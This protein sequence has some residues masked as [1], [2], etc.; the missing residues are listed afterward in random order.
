MYVYDQEVFSGLNRGDAIQYNTDAKGDVQYV[1]KYF[2]I[3]NRPLKKQGTTQTS[4][5]A[6][7]NITN[8]LCTI[9]GEVYGK[10]GDYLTLY[11]A[12]NPS[13]EPKYLN[14]TTL[15]AKVYLYDRELDRIEVISADDIEIGQMVF[16]RSQVTQVL[17]IYAIK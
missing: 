15:Q 7:V 16:I 12:D 2:D 11:L 13:T 14:Y 8:E 17:D 6:I 5:T 10:N 3:Q 1:E 9:Y 4:P